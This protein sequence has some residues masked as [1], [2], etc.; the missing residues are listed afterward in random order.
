MPNDSERRGW[1]AVGRR[2]GTAKQQVEVGNS[3]AR[4][5]LVRAYWGV[6]S[7]STWL[8]LTL[9]HWLREKPSPHPAAIKKLLKESGR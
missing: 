3:S 1:K 8:N 6:R 5:A 7:P 9:R 2:G 4:R